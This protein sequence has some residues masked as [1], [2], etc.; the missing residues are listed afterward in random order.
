MLAADVEASL[1]IC[2]PVAV[3]VDASGFNA[4]VFCRVGVR[5]P[6]GTWLL[7]TADEAALT[8]P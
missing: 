7:P 5:S 6:D 1:A 8:P 2:D 4:N 3:T